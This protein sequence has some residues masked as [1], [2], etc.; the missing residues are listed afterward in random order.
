MINS[1]KRISELL[2]YCYDGSAT[3]DDISELKALLD[4]DRQAL[5]Y[6]VEISMN[7]NYF[8]CLAQI[9]MSPSKAVQDGDTDFRE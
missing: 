2:L 7:L 6:C 9:P 4:Q 5:E 1:T 8:H 3:Q